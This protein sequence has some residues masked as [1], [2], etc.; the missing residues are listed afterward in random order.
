VIA[1]V[2]IQ[3][4]PTRVYISS[5]DAIA[6]IDPTFAVHA[7][8]DEVQPIRA[9]VEG[10][11]GNVSFTLRPTAMRYMGIP[12]LGATC[13]VWRAEKGEAIAEFTGTVQKVTATAQGV[14]VQAAQ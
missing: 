2:E 13:I 5:A 11:N 4:A 8:L 14:T 10:E 9:G 1:W 12:P 6:Y 3:D 7:L